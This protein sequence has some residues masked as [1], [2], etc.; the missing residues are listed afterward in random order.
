MRFLEFRVDEIPDDGNRGGQEPNRQTQRR[1]PDDGSRAGQEPNRPAE[2]DPETLV[3]GPPYPSELEHTVSIIQNRLEELGYGVG[4]T[5]SDGKY[6]PRTARAIAAF[7][8]DFNRP[9]DGRTFTSADADALATATPKEKPSP[10]GNHASGWTRKGSADNLDDV[11]FAS[12]TGTGRVRMRNSGATRNKALDP[13]LMNV[14]EKAAEASGVDVVV[15][16]GGQDA[17]GQGTRRTGSIRHDNGLA[18]DVWI[19]SNGDRLST[20]RNNPVVAKFIAACVL[21]GARGIGAGP[22]YMNNVGIHVD[23][24]GERAGSRTWGAG[25]SSSATPNYVNVAYAM[26][27]R[28]RTR[29]A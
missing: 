24:W 15:F 13:R 17:Q 28:G 12:G 19:Y 29:V 14:L 2:S 21:F 23:L 25:G 26:G 8:K 10:T 27:A 11:E 7:K 5:G 3:M 9:G 18:A 4:A 16:S 20:A 6:G 22:G 1:D